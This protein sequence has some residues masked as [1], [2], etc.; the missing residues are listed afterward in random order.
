[1]RS[2]VPT[3]TYRRLSRCTCAVVRLSRLLRVVSGGTADVRPRVL[4]QKGAPGPKFNS[5][6]GATHSH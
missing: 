3:F 6:R 4:P 1:M 2:H 5:A